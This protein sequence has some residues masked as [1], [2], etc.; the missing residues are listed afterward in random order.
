MYKYQHSHHTHPSLTHSLT[1]T[2]TLTHSLTHTHTHTHSLTHETEFEISEEVPAVKGWNWGELQFAGPSLSF[3][4]EQ[5]PAF[6]INLA[7]V[8]N[9]TATKTEAMLEFH[10]VCEEGCFVQ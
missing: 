3:L 5:H 6:E 8:S 10:K 4:I 7:T 1:H 9:A 2:H